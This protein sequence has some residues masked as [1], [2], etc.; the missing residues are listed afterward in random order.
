MPDESTR[1]A[2][3]FVPAADS[4]LYRLGSSVIGYDC[5]TGE[6]LPP[7]PELR[8]DAEFWR[9][10][11]T[12]PRRY[13]FHATLKAPFRLSPS[14]SE[15][16]LVSAFFSFV[17]SGHRV[18]QIP[19]EVRMIEGFAAIVPSRASAALAALADQCTTAFDA[20]RAPLSAE[21]MARRVSAGLSPRQIDHLKR[22]GYPYVFEDFRFHMTLTGQIPA[23][24]GDRVLAD[25]RATFSRLTARPLAIDRI[26]LLKQEGE[27]AR[28]RVLCHAEPAAM[29]RTGAGG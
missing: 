17:G 29:T 26:A 11:T 10:L 19:P 5:Y 14:C 13:G 25:L 2:I 9:A 21:E 15:D 7:P 22:W 28:F 12:D 23:D 1:Y 16:Q 3:Y 8:D 18:S 20:F 6:D 4:E 24:R 27:R